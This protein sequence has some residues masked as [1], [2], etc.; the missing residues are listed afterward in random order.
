MM[1]IEDRIVR[2]QAHMKDEKPLH[3]GPT[4]SQRADRKALDPLRKE[5]QD[6]SLM[7]EEASLLLQKP[8]KCLFAILFSLRDVCMCLLLFVLQ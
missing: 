8:E 7:T 4:S 3:E 6:M 1:G 2:I 5:K